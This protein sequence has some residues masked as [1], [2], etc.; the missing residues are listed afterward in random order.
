MSEPRATVVITT[1]NRRDD[2]R[3]AVQ[4]A[5]SQQPA[6]HVLVVDDGSDDGTSEMIR[7]DFPQVE[8]HRVEVSRGYIVGRNE[9]ARF[10]KTPYIVSIDD[11]AAFSSPFVVAQTIQEF[12]GDRVAGVA[13]PYIDVNRS[14]NIIPQVPPLA[15][16]NQW[17]VS[18]TYTG[19]AHALR[20]DRFLDAGG[21]RESLFHQGEERDLA[22]RLLDRGYVIRLGKADPIEHY[23]SPNRA[24]NRMSIFGRRNDV[25]YAWH[26]V[27]WRYLPFDLIGTTLKGLRY[28]LKT[29]RF[30]LMLR[31]L[32]C[33]WFAILP[34]L[35]ARKPISVHA[36]RLNRRMMREGAL[37]FDQ[38]KS[39]IEK[40]SM[41]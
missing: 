36:Y 7:A 40:T 27:P 26:N 35:G 2:L 41:R 33:G 22:I 23:E 13:I 5:L 31:G 19:T 37:T 25:L 6:V 16:Q 39:E 11:D 28:G 3:R 15:V 9:G 29:G 32:V 4:S 14:P 38:L 34:N 24:S 1:K 20:R 10:A 8:L 12:D 30:F 17:Y 21:Y 18:Y